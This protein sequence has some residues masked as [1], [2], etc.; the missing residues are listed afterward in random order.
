[1]VN[2]VL[3]NN[4]LKQYDGLKVTNKVLEVYD[5]INYLDNVIEDFLYPSITSNCLVRYE[6]FIKGVNSSKLENFVLDKLLYELR[7]ND[8]KRKLFMTKLTIALRKLNEIELKIFKYSVYDGL[9]VFDISEKIHFGFTRTKEIKKSA[10]VK[11]LMALNIDQDCL[12][13]GDK[14]RVQSYFQ[15]KAGATL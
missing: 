2:K 5:L 1:M 14:L 3:S 8:Y 11:F 13:G 6:Q 12:K 15:N 4:I 9:E 7:G 10:F